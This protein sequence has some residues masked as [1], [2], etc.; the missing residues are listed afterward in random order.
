MDYL[1]PAI[2]KAKTS[3]FRFEGLQ[4]Y[5]GEDGDEA[6]LIFYRQGSY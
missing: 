5:S 6:V 4:D 3:L 2:E 1:W